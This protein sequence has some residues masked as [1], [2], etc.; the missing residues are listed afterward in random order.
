V[1]GAGLHK[2]REKFYDFYSIFD[3]LYRHDHK[4]IGRRDKVYYISEKLKVLNLH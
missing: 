2:Q 3:Y 4:E 1:G